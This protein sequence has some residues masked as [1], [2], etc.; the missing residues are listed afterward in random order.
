MSYSARLVNPTPIPVEWPWH[1]GVVLKI[2]PFGYLDLNAQ[3]M[4]Q[5]MPDQPGADG[6]QQLMAHYGVFLQDASKT[7]E[8]QAEDALKAAI[9]AKT[10]LVEDCEKNVR[11]RAAN[12]G[13]A[14]NEDA[15]QVELERSGYKRL[16]DEIKSLVE[17]L[18]TVSAVNQKSRRAM[19]KQFDPERTL[20]FTTPPK[21]F[22]SALAMKLFLN[23]PENTELRK[24]QEAYMAQFNIAAKKKTEETKGTK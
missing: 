17:T 23:L 3:T 9:K 18:K 10:D 13:N 7:Y 8:S 11:N 1:R 4:E 12:T 6:V 21:E 20:L 16:R 5:F 19:H 22:P 14:H 2:E 15:I 24:Q